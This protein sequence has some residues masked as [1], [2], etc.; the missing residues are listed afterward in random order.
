MSTPPGPDALRSPS[1]FRQNA[2]RI[3]VPADPR[4]IPGMLADFQASMEAAVREYAEQTFDGTAS[5]DGVVATVTAYGA[6]T[7]IHIGALAKR[8]TDNLTLGDAVVEAVRDAQANARKAWAE[9]MSTATLFG[10]PAGSFLPP[11]SDGPH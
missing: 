1:A 8:Q 2:E 9:R 11:P 5:V 6:V 10:I 4:R 7:G 3:A